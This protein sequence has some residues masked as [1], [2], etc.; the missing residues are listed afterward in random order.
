MRGM[1]VK[2]FR[3][4]KDT[5]DRSECAVSTLIVV[6]RLLQ[7]PHDLHMLWLHAASLHLTPRLQSRP[8]QHSAICSVSSL[9]PAA[10]LT[11]TAPDHP[12]THPCNL[13]ISRPPSNHLPP[14]SQPPLPAQRLTSAIS[15]AVRPCDVTA[16]ALAPPSNSSFTILTCPLPAM[17]QHSV[18]R[19]KAKGGEAGRDIKLLTCS[20]MQSSVAEL[21]RSVD[22]PSL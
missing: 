6:L 21:V 10:P 11:K 2:R 13:I 12:T 4:T 7:H 17:R 9:K 15:M 20:P 14:P 3:S 5:Q 19:E 16:R 8:C 18:R 1:R 22:G